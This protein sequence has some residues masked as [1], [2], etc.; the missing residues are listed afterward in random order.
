MLRCPITEPSAT[1]TEMEMGVN[2]VAPMIA[3][4][5]APAAAPAD[6]AISAARPSPG[7]ALCT[8]MDDYRSLL[9]TDTVAAAVVSEAVVVSVVAVAIVAFGATTG[10]TL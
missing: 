2:T 8:W 10:R 3:P 1:P 5:E 4:A 7:T 6:A 9:Q